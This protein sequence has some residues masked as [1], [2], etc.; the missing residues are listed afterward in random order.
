MESLNI[1]C[2]TIVTMYISIYNDIHDDA[3]VHNGDNDA[4]Y[5]TVILCYR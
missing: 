5:D 1:I 2:I 4:V 3:Y